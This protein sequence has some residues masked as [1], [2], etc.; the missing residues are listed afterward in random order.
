MLRHTHSEYLFLL[1][2]HGVRLGRFFLGQFP[3]FLSVVQ[4]EGRKIFLRLMKISAIHP[5]AL[6]EL[7]EFAQI[8]NFEMA[9]RFR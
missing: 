6:Q 3:V 7:Q 1:Q 9:K 2:T 4:E 5:M 8:Q